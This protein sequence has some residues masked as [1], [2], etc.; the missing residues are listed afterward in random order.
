[1]SNKLNWLL[2]ALL[3][4]SAAAASADSV[5]VT[6]GGLIDSASVSG[7]SLQAGDINFEFEGNSDDW[8]EYGA[9]TEEFIFGKV[10]EASITIECS[11]AD[12]EN[13]IAG[14]GADGAE[15]CTSYPVVFQ[16]DPQS[17]LSEETPNPCQENLAEGRVTLNLTGASCTG[18]TFESG[19]FS[20]ATI[21]APSVDGISADFS[22]TLIASGK[23]K[24][25]LSVSPRTQGPQLYVIY[26][27]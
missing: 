2:A 5:G 19:V 8:T 22:G 15:S 21:T 27:S 7:C 1:M 3:T 11:D 23:V 10:A 25:E 18:C 14:C 6:I 24:G 13:P 9:N 26:G 12:G 16:P 4:T 17:C 20:V